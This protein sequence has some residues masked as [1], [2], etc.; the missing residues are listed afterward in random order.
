MPIAVIIAALGL[1]L[2]EVV[3]EQP[4]GRIDIFVYRRLDPGQDV[5]C[6]GIVDFLGLFHLLG[7]RGVK[8][9]LFCRR[10]DEVA[11]L[12]EHPVDNEPRWNDVL[13]FPDLETQQLLLV[14]ALQLSHSRKVMLCIL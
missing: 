5:L 3:D 2:A 13:A 6:L 7:Q 12:V 10:R 8:D 14:L 1:Q 4:V 11:H 9:I